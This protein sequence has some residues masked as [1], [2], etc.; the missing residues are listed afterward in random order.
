[1]NARRPSVMQRLTLVWVQPVCSQISAY[2]KPSAFSHSA[3]SSWGLSRCSASAERRNRS[4]LTH[5]LLGR[6]QVPG[7]LAIEVGLLGGHELLALRAHRHRLVL[8]DGVDPSCARSGSSVA[9]R[10]TKISI[11]R[12]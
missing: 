6:G 12:W 5:L 4:K 11:V 3:R 10:R 2:E 7:L 8:A 9:A 1:M